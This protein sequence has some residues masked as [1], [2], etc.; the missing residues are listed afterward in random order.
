MLLKYF[1]L[2][3]ELTQSM[4]IFKPFTSPSLIWFNRFEIPS[5]NS[6]TKYTLAN[7]VVFA[8]PKTNSPNSN[9]SPQIVIYLFYLLV[10][11]VFAEHSTLHNAFHYWRATQ[12]YSASAFKQLCRNF[13]FSI[14][15][16]FPLISSD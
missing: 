4:G 14:K 9:S 2:R 12:H 3:P 11:I 16:M 10:I 6:L 15:A 8:G 5:V 1:N 7:C 13:F